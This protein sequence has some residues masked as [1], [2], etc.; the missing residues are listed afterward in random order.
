MRALDLSG[1]RGERAGHRSLRGRPSVGD[2]DCQASMSLVSQTG[3]TVDRADRRWRLTPVAVGEPG[4]ALDRAAQLAEAVDGPADVVGLLGRDQQP[5]RSRADP[6]PCSPPPT[7]TC[8]SGTPRS[9]APGPDA[10][11]ARFVASP[12]A[13]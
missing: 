3:V 7:S 2:A 9:E 5:D 13:M 8:G 6:T 11:R 1:L 4:A 10:H 12:K